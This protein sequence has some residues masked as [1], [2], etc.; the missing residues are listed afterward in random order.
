MKKITL[1][2]A[3]L[4]AILTAKSQDTLCHYFKGKKVTEFNYQLSHIICES[5]QYNKFYTVKVGYRQVLCLNFK[6]RKPRVRKVILTYPDGTKHVEVLTS[7]NNVYYT[8]FGPL[9]VEVSKSKLFF[10]IKMSSN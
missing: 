7:E 1:S 8:G 9:K 10:P 2:V 4:A 5:E 3:L 6:D